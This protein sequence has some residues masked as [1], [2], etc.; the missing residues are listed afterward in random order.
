EAEADVGATP[1]ALPFGTAPEGATPASP[2]ERPPAWGGSGRAAD[3][4]R[5]SPVE[6]RPPSLGGSGDAGAPRARPVEYRSASARA[7]GDARVAPTGR[8]PAAE[9]GGDDSVPAAAPPPGVRAT[10]ASP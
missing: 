6:H 3:F 1:P 4:P 10:Q 8:P 2:V 7:A 5:S 9:G